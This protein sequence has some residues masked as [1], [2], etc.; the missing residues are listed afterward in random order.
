[1]IGPRGAKGPKEYKEVQAMVKTP[2][3]IHRGGLIGSNPKYFNIV[4]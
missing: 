3:Y 4:T 1:V 2:V